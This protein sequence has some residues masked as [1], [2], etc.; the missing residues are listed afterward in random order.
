MCARLWEWG[1]GHILIYIETDSL[2]I[3]G[4]CW[5]FTHTHTYK[6]AAICNLFSLACIDV[7]HQ[8]SRYNARSC[9]PW[10]IRTKCMTTVLIC[11]AG[12][13]WISLTA[14]Y[15][16]MSSEFAQIH[17]IMATR[18]CSFI[19]RQGKTT[20]NFTCE[21]TATTAMAL[22]LYLGTTL[23]LRWEQVLTEI[24]K[25]SR[26]AVSQLVFALNSRG[27]TA[28]CWSYGVPDK[29]LNANLFQ[30]APPFQLDE[31]ISLS[32]IMEKFRGCLFG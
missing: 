25:T 20:F 22:T 4:K 6:H 27:W 1:R 15:E 9:I 11:T 26:Y 21:L 17:I 14:D 2:L 28:C 13:W 18:R 7:C 32:T 8:F 19:V 29:L 5:H 16:K 23:W 12:A 24:V 30:F 10:R 3:Y 31:H